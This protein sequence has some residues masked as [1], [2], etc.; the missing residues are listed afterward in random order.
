[1][2]YKIKDFDEQYIEEILQ[3]LEHQ[4]MTEKEKLIYLNKIFKQMNQKIRYYKDIGID[5]SIGIFLV[6]TGIG[7]G[8]GNSEDIYFPITLCVIGIGSILFSTVKRNIKY[9]SI[10][11][12]EKAKS[13][14][15]KI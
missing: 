5:L 12:N 13:L 1:M 7:N 8:I 3:N 2:T 11:K 15:K 10:S 4:N 6:G 9:S 14:K